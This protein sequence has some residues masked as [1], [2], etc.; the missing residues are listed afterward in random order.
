MRGSPIWV[1]RDGVLV[2]M[3]ETDFEDLG[4]EPGHAIVPGLVG[5]VGDVDGAM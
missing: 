1:L 3:P 4:D 5:W 2:Q